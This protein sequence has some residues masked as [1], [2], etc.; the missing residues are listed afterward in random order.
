MNEAQLELEYNSQRPDIS[1]T[2]YGRNVHKMV[3]YAMSIADREERNRCANAIISV[4]GQLFPY[5]R[6]VE[7]FKHKLWDHLHIMA[8]FQLDVDSPYPK[9][10][11]EALAA[12]PETV[13]YP[14]GHYKFGHYGTLI[15][16]LVTKA[17][18]IEDDKERQALLVQLVLLMKRSFVNWNRDLVTDQTIIDNLSVLSD[19]KLQ[20]PNQ[21]EL[22]AH[23]RELPNHSANTNASST[24]RKNV[25]KK[26]IHNNNK[27][28]RK[29]RY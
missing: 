21:E 27:P 13:A 17:C 24:V 28:N 7:D 23:M 8:G 12:K 11:P 25:K 15:P 5:V 16:D 22:M 2:E 29:K 14:K 3:E 6:D 19:G 9:P 20:I 4:M 18:K 26:P 10:S 1:I